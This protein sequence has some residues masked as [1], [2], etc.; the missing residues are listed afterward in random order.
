MPPLI[1]GTLFFIKIFQSLDKTLKNNKIVII[2]K[3]N[4]YALLSIIF[5]KKLKLNIS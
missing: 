1:R 3:Y 4:K 5:Y 2:I